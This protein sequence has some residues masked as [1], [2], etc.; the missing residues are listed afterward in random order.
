[1]EQPAAAR[2]A[3]AR[4]LRRTLGLPSDLA[5]PA[6]SI[7]GAPQSNTVPTSNKITLSPRLGVSYPVTRDAALYFAYG[8]FYQMPALGT[9]FD[10]ADYNKLRQLQAGG[11]DYGVLGNPDVKPE[12]TVQYQFGY[13]QAVNAWLGVDVSVFYKDIRD[14]LGVEFIDTYNGAEYARLTN[15]DFGNVTGFTVA[16]DQH[17]VGVGEREPRLHLAS[18][19]RG[20]RATRARPPR[21]RRPGG[22]APAPGAAQLGPAPH[23]QP[24]HERGA[25]QELQR[26]RRAENRQRSAL[27]AAAHHRVRGRAGD[28]LGPQAER[29][30]ARPARRAPRLP[31]GLDAAIFARVFNVFDSRF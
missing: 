7:T 27:H 25:T 29:P 13:K 26:Q 14:L 16:L 23:L 19:R 18:S 11:I 12:R 17:Q 15:V 8:H 24:D 10:N 3:A 20:T 5:N 2:R 22:S 28:Q 1:M 31:L 21:A 30:A 6:N 4:L 9:M